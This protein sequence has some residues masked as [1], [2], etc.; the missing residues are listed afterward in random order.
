[1]AL[2]LIELARRLNAE[3]RGS[4]GHEIR[5]VASLFRA[6]PDEISFVSEEKYL[7]LLSNTRA[8]AILLKAA[9]ADRFAGNIL[10]TG[11]PHLSFAR[12]A[13][14]LSPPRP[15]I[16]GI[17]AS[18]S[19]DPGAHIARTAWIGPHCV[20]AAGARIGDHCQ[21][22]PGSHVSEGATIGA[23]SRLVARV[24]IGPNCVVGDSG[25]IQP[26]AVIG[27][28]GFGFARDGERWI[29]VPQL[30]RVV[31]GKEVEVGANTTIDR[32]A[33][34]DTVI[35]DGV[36]LDNL[37]QVAHN[38]RIGEH[39][40]VAAQVGIAGSTTIGKRC[41]IGG[42]AGIIGHLEIADDVHITATTLVTSDLSRAGTYASNLKAT[43][44]REWRRA[45]AR[46]LQLESLVQRLKQIEEK[47]K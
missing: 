27:S 46:L 4:P 1:M 6:G 9:H 7:P 47:L 36:K 14:M 37:I 22:G 43:P 44:V 32:G 30:G 11:N 15:C 42:Q 33:L 18:A 34:D 31:L 10:V 8:G 26:G 16:P 40:A 23:G 17:D 41:T 25:L 39:T 5:G 21:I 19:V 3:L 2:T 38:V 29:K 13:A 24:Y 45:L 28:D 12:V 35:D 20:I